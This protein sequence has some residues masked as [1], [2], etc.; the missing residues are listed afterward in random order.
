M[1][2]LRRAFWLLVSGLL[3]VAT[4]AHA[5]ALLQDDGADSGVVVSV[6][7]PAIDFTL[8]DLSGKPWRLSEL[9]GRVVLVNFWASWCPPC[10]GEIPSLDRFARQYDPADVIVL[11]VNVEGKSAA[12]LHDFLQ[13][14][15]H[16]FTVLLDREQRVQQQ[17]GVRQL[18][19]TFLLDRQG[20]IVK[21]FI[22]GLNWTAPEV[23]RQID[24][25]REGGQ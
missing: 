7:R 21:R 23:K 3:A 10:V 17:Y 8:S 5:S 20:M 2:I 22:G 12:E 1:P 15:P 4:G 25:L 6:G 14:H 9:K 24:F 11:A 13:R 19:E 16:G 18:P